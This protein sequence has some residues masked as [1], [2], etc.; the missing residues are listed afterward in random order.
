MAIVAAPDIVVLHLARL[1]WQGSLACVV[2]SSEMNLRAS[3]GNA[4][5]VSLGASQKQSKRS[6]TNEP[7]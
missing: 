2:P 3:S 1:V 6:E 4:S 7:S 5:A